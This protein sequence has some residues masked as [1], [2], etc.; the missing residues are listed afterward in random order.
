MGLVFG[1]LAVA[2][3]WALHEFAGLPTWAAIF[4]GFFAVFG[5]LGDAINILYINRRI[6]PIDRQQKGKSG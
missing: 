5:A 2:V 1:L 6:H 3:L 4:L